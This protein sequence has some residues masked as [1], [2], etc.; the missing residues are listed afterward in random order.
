MKRFT[1]CVEV[2]VQGMVIRRTIELQVGWRGLTAQVFASDGAAL[3][4]P[5][6]QKPGDRFTVRMPFTLQPSGSTTTGL[7]R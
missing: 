6:A 1:I 3:T 4:A 7:G 2:D 5:V